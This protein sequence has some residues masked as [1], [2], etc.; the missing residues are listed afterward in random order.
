M[1]YI[2]PT[3]RLPPGNMSEIIQIK[4]LGSGIICTM[5]RA[6]MISLVRI[7]LTAKP[8]PFRT[9]GAAQGTGVYG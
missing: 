7:R 3:T 8:E 9:C 2:T 4:N 1:G 5:K 6:S